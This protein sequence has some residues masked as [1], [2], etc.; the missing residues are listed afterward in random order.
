MASS[1][2]YREDI[3]KELVNHILQLI[4]QQKE[5]LIPGQLSFWRIEALLGWLC[6][7]RCERDQLQKTIT[8][9]RGCLSDKGATHCLRL[10]DECGCGEKE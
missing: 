3:K 6:L 8:N 1:K 5:P 9:L 4:G 2:E 10:L 7:A